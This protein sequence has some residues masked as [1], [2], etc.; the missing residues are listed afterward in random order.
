MIDISEACILTSSEAS[1]LESKAV[2][3]LI[4]EVEKRTGVRLKTVYDWPSHDKP[5]IVVGTEA[6]LEKLVKPY[7]GF[8]DRLDRP[9][10]EGYRVAVCGKEHTVFIVGADARGALYGVGKL[11]RKLYFKEGSIKVDENL[12]FSSTPRYS[13]RGVQLGYRPKSNAYDAWTVEQFDQYIRELSI[14]G[15]NSIEILPPRTDDLPRNRLMKLDPLEMMVKLSEIID[16]Y[17][18]DVWVW[19]PNMFSE[20]EYRKPR[21]VEKELAER[22]EI[23]SRLPRVD[24][25][26]IPGGDP[27]FLEADT[28]FEWAE[29]VSEVLRRYHP[30]AKIWLSPQHTRGSD[31]WFE[32]FYAN[33]K[34][35]PEWLGGVVFGPFV[36]TPLPKLRKIV[37]SRYPIRRYPDITHTL[38]CQYPVPEWDRAFAVTLGRECIN[39]RPRALKHIHNMFAEY[40]IGSICY[41]E[42]INDDVNKFVWLDQEW[43]PDTPV[44]ETL[45]DYVRLFI[46]YEYADEV[47]QGL[48]A[49]EENWSGPLIANNQ[50]DITF[51]QW[52]K[53]ELKASK[54]VLDNYRFQMGL[55]RAYYDVYIKR[56]L[57]HE[58]ELERQA[59]EALETSSSVGSIEALKKAKHILEKVEKEPVLQSYRRR[60]VELAD[61][62]FASIG[63]QLSVARHGAKSWD[64][65]AFVDDIDMPL[66]NW[67][68]LLRKISLILKAG[69]EDER[70]KEIRRLIDRGNPGPGGFYVDFG[71]FRSLRYI[72]NRL[73]WKEDPGRL[74]SP[75]ISFTPILLH[76]PFKPGEAPMEWIS[77]LSTLYDNPIILS[78]DNLDPSS[79]YTV[80]VTYVGFYGGGKV[81]LLADEK[82][83]IHDF[84]EI[85]NT[86]SCLEFPIPKEA[87]SNGRLKLTWIPKDAVRT[88]I[89]EIWIKRRGR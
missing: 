78:I 74:S 82:Y 29:K 6:S 75:F 87:V 57:I 81:K 89:A 41:S 79:N 55:L 18:L 72:S 56:R 38:L 59:L 40:A 51:K 4:E 65:G 70:I 77:C 83:L 5:V 45:R 25:V 80:K 14:F 21:I 34:S 17:G 19:Y 33:L 60:C 42:G 1:R 39:P 36:K 8:L 16:S 24:A 54:K 85:K 20:S 50:V 47:A 86:I 48:M 69:S 28:L 67:R 64:R 61:K 11:L 62:L 10:S 68:Y 84:I 52:R 27:G 31:S 7:R 88:S 76:P 30:N 49:L 58:T 46:G 71:C 9:G 44:V 13:L 63:A 22:E 15:A 73:E 32:S 37:P 2:A 43:C 23:F 35:E 12:S 53:I 26:F 3:V 66:T